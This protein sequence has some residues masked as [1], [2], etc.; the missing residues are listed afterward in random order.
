MRARILTPADTDQVRRVL[1]ADPVSNIFVA[2]RV[3]AGVLNPHTPGMLWGWPTSEV[4]SIL[5]VGQNMVPVA[6]DQVA[7]SAFA[8]AVGRR[9]SAQAIL[10]PAGQALPLWT[11]LSRRWGRNYSMTR[12]VRPRQPMMAITKPPIWP[13]DIRVR[14][15][16]FRE[17][18]SYLDAFLAMYRDEVGGGS[19]EHGIELSF[20]QYCHSLV[21]NNRAFGIVE[22]G[23][24]IFKADIGAAANSIAQVQGVWLAP[25]YRGKGLAAG[26]MSAVTEYALAEHRTACLYVN[27]FNVRA[28]RCYERVGF[29]VVDEFATVLF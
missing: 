20:R 12:Q 25:E 22:N 16:T 8:E 21:A 6:A 10:G 17:F 14:P 18:D 11:A 19:L 4:R 2:S 15:I 29:T 26:A 13:A 7:I 9:R 28:V 27:S 23:R 24:V 1:E 5:H 3:E